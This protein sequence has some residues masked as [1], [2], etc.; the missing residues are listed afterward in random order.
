MGAQQPPAAS[1]ELD[2]DPGGAR[3]PDLAELS[4]E[5]LPGL[6][7]ELPGPPW[8]DDQPLVAM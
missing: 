3:L 4:P 6:P 8:F 7:P 2:V 5:D 1:A